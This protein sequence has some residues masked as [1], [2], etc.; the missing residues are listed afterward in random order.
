LLDEDVAVVH[1]WQSWVTWIPARVSGVTTAG[2]AQAN[3]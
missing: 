1:G 3:G 2:A